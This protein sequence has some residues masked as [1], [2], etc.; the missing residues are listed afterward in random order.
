[1]NGA[2]MFTRDPAESAAR[3]DRT[4]VDD[5][6]GVEREELAHDE[7]AHDRDAE[8][9]PQLRAHPCSQ[10]ERQRAQER[11]HRGHHD[12][13]EPQETGLVD[14]IPGALALPALASRAKS[15]I[16]IAFFFTMRSTE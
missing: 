2:E 11:G 16:M 13:A 10:G 14:R 4:Q 9:P 1:M 6:R 8:G 12:R 7:P 5:R 3:D 15:I